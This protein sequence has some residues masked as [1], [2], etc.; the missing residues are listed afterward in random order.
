[1]SFN[2]RDHFFK[3]AKKEGF[4]ARS[5]YKLDEI[6][7]RYRVMRSGNHVLDLGCAPG[8]WSQVAMKVVGSKGRVEGLDLKPVS[9]NAPNARFFVKDAFELQ[10]EDLQ[11]APYDVLLSDMAPN[12]TGIMI[13]DQALSEEL[14]L[15]VLE[16]SERFL[17][18]GGHLV[19]KFFMGPG[20]K[21][22]EN[23]VRQRFTKLQQLRPEAT[24]SSSKEIF[25]IGIG[26]K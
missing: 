2:P 4:L 21:N 22:V 15:K 14:C 23:E 25:L 16:L 26:K 9:L 17:K 6:Q 3:K 19:M 10:P 8:A 13:R 12:T 5:A 11:F 1:M 7:K 18:P 20:A 24:R